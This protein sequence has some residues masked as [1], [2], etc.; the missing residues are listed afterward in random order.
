MVGY[1]LIDTAPK[2]VR[3]AFNEL[4]SLPEITELH[5]LFG[6]YDFIAKIDSD[7]PDKIGK[8]VTNRIRRVDG[9]ID[10]KT[11]MGTTYKEL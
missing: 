11:L 4:V 9:V 10:T 6:E 2:K 5:P 1:V 3:E 7:D 8:I